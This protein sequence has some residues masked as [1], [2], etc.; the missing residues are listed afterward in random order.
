MATN[1]IQRR[2]R[3]SFLIGFLIAL[4]AMAIVVALLFVKISSLNEDLESTK[5]KVPEDRMVYVAADNIEAGAKVTPDHF[6]PKYVKTNADLSVYLDPNAF[7]EYD[8]EGNLLEYYTQAEIPADSMVLSSMIVKTG[9]EIRADE[10]II[11]YNMIVLPTQLKNGDYIDIRY[12]LPTS[13]DYIILSKKYVEQTTA[14]SVWI[15]VTEE[16]ILTMNSAIVDSYTIQGSKIHATI[17]TN[18]GTQE[19]ATPTYPVND[20]ILNLMNSN[21]NIIDEAKKELVKRWNV[22]SNPNDGVTDY[23]YGRNNL[24]SYT[25][26]LNKDS[27]NGQVEG[28][29][30]EEIGKISAS[31]S[32]Y[33]SNLEGT[34]L[35]GIS[36]Y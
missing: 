21:S 28:K 26:N 30:Q 9:T 33:V 8:E 35:V 36:E 3:Q 5:K 2:A 29:V 23:R 14:T 6:I 17:Y 4:I 13:E 25:S 1:P 19:A 34:G 15:K 7:F 24:D 11:E 31:R 20:N 18:P 12:M 22:D 32:E 27:F 16:E 10:R